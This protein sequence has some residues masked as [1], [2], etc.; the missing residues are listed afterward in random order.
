MLAATFLELNGVEFTAMEESVIDVTL[1][2][3]SGKLKQAPY[4]GWA[5]IPE[6]AEPN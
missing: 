6:H 5:R 1:A 2:L 4:A 3:A